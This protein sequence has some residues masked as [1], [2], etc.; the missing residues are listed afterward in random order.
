MIYVSTHYHFGMVEFLAGSEVQEMAKRLLAC[1]TKEYRLR[2]SSGTL[3]IPE[4]IPQ[5]SP[6]G[7]ISQRR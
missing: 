2:G 6:S 5:K 1:S 3:S 7:K 4:V